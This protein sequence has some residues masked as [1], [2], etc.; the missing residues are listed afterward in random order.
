M[1]RGLLMVVS[2]ANQWARQEVI[3]GNKVRQLLVPECA[4]MQV[5][6]SG[7][8]LQLHSRY[9]RWPACRGSSA[10][11]DGRLAAVLPVVRTGRTRVEWVGGCPEFR[12]TS[13]A[14]R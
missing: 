12:G 11:S 14:V 5:D 9:G 1:I 4:D 6:D 7:D 13:V 8:E 3:G 10:A 2:T